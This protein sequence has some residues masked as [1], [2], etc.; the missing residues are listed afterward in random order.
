[1]TYLR[2]PVEFLSAKLYRK[3]QG[4][5]AAGKSD[6]IP[7]ADAL[8]NLLFH[9]VDVRADGGHPVCEDC[10]VDPMLFIA[11]HGGA[12]KPDSFVKRFDP[13]KARIV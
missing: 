7:D 8:C 13:R 6:R 3:V 1:M 2:L 5:G 9:F 12:G 4:G 11:V 10:I